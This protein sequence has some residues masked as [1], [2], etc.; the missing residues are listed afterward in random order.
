[1]P[2]EGGQWCALAAGSGG[3][4]AK[5]TCS[6]CPTST[7]QAKS[8]HRL[9]NCS[10]WDVCG[11]GEYQKAAGSATSD[12]SCATHANKCNANEYQAA[13]PSGKND[14]VCKGAG[15]CKNG[16]LISAAGRTQADQCGAC[17][18]GFYLVSKACQVCPTNTY[19]SRF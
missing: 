17:D 9:T 8:E 5:R 1:M 19:H 13:A 4:T 18:I 14:R 7:F 6:A 12:R 2:C 10:K 11:K 3:E 16:A 15:S